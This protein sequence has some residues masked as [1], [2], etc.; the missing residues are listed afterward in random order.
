MIMNVI[1]CETIFV[2][3]GWN[4]KNCTSL[5]VL[6]LTIRSFPQRPSGEE[7]RKKVSMYCHPHSFIPRQ[8][9][10]GALSSRSE[11]VRPQARIPPFSLE[12]EGGE[13]V[14]V[15]GPKVTSLLVQMV[16]KCQLSVLLPEGKH[17]IKRQ[18]YS[19]PFTL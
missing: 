7:L 18:L 5:L 16:F 4:G 15:K 10:N 1:V 14:G 9:W 17:T 11:A 12:G 19:K 13:C 3:Q 6:D 2:F 8:P